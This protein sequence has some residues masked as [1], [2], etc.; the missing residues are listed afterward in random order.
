MTFS[1]R[2]LYFGVTPFRGHRSFEKVTEKIGKCLPVC[3]PANLVAHADNSVG[4]VGPRDNR[5]SQPLHKTPLTLTRFLARERELHLSHCFGR[6]LHE[7]ISLGACGPRPSRLKP[8]AAR[9]AALHHCRQIIVGFAK[10]SGP[11]P[12]YL[13]CCGQPSGIPSIPARIVCEPV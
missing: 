4:V 6:R 3:R 8:C 1:E 2:L 9:A 12:L 11:S 7:S 10:Q 13:V 5:S